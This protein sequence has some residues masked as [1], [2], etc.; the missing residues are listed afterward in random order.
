MIGA[1]VRGLDVE[2]TLDAVEVWH[3]TQSECEA[4][5]FVAVAPFADLHHPDSRPDRGGPG[6][7][8]M[9]RPKRLGGVGTPLVFEFAAAEFGPRIGRSAYA[10]RAL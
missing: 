10:G 3:A 5:I 4:R 6:L 7:P 8:G 2:Q 1:A 9:E